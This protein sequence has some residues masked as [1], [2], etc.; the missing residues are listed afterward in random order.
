[1]LTGRFDE[2]E[3]FTKTFL[4]ERLSDTLSLYRDYVNTKYGDAVDSILG[5]GS[6]LSLTTETDQEVQTQN[7]KILQ[8]PLER[9][10]GKDFQLLVHSR[11]NDG[12]LR[13]YEKTSDEEQFFTHVTVG[14]MAGIV[15]ETADPTDIV[16]NMDA[17]L[18]DYFE[19]IKIAV[20][21]LVCP[22]ARKYFHKDLEA[23]WQVVCPEGRDADPSTRQAFVTSL[24]KDEVRCKNLVKAVKIII[25]GRENAEMMAPLEA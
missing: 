15:V 1:M 17:D 16:D 22:M 14:Q 21:L 10:K 3:T 18:D 6:H 9:A 24:R 2:A 11:V 23:T 8:S 19:P 4:P 20:Q 5:T 13:G 25:R 12:M 7:S